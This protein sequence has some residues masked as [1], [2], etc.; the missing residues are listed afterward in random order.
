MSSAAGRTPATLSAQLGATAALIDLD[1]LSR[2]LPAG[3][4]PA[5]LEEARRQRIEEAL[6]TIDSHLEQQGRVPR[7]VFLRAPGVGFPLPGEEQEEHPDP[8]RPR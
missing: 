2:T 4:G 6:A 5:Q 8:R 1:A 3:A 7:V